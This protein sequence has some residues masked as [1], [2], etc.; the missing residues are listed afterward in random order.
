M[1]ARSSQGLG[2]FVDA[3]EIC[4]SFAVSGLYL[5]PDRVPR[6]SAPAARLFLALEPPLFS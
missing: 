2:L 4:L 3:L 1:A 5:S 6:Q